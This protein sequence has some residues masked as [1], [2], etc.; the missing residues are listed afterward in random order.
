MP[1]DFTMLTI[2]DR[3]AL[4]KPV[5]KGKVFRT[6]KSMPRGKSQGP[7]G[8]SVEFSIFYWHVIGDFFFLQIKLLLTF[9][10][11]PKSLF[12]GVKLMLPLSP[13]LAPLILSMI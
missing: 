1:D 13:T 8:M 12:L 3:D 10:T 7:D 2:E 4:T 5:S 6:L 9:S 11:P